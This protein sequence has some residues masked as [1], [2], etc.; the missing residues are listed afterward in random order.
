MDNPGEPLESTPNA[1]AGT[2]DLS[3]S[4]VR[5]RLAFLWLIGAGL[6]AL[7]MIGQSIF[8][9]YEGKSTDAWSWFL[10]NVM[11]TLGL[12]LSVL[13]ADAILTGP[14]KTATIATVD[15]FFY[16]V[17]TSL[18]LVYLATFAGVILVW[19]LTAFDDPLEL[20]TLSN[21]WM[22]PLQALVVSSLSALF[23]TRK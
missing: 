5:Q 20:M 9:A 6:I 7:V 14:R 4:L 10:P 3:L 1:S 11:P 12:I 15:R 19:P 2:T 8:G 17:A 21:L 22:G 13:G 18:S 16:R 23:F